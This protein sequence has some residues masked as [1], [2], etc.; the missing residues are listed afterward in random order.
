M[1]IRAVESIPL[2]KSQVF[3]CLKEHMAAYPL[4]TTLKGEFPGS[5]VI[6][7]DEVTEGQACTCEIGLKGA[8][9]APTDPIMIS[10]CD[11]GVDYDREAYLRLENDPSVDIIVWSFTN[12]PT[13]QLYPHMYAWLDVDAD[14]NIKNVS[15]KKPLPGAKHAIIGTMF[16]RT[17]AIYTEGLK[18]IY[19]KQIRTNGEFY[20]DNLLNPL[21]KA[22]YTVKVF[23]VDA[24]IC[25]GTPNDY[26]TYTYWLEHFSKRWGAPIL[27]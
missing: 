16:F 12:N 5:T 18:E 9:I 10:A 22:G 21:I 26:K 20:V 4:E 7:I 3:I 17:A 15:V 13:G 2:C 14:N 24:Y 23:P 1:I 11:N 8:G 6:G 27:M 25:W 19:E